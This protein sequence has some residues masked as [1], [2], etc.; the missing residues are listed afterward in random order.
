MAAYVPWKN[1][2]LL[3]SASSA[4]TA[5]LSE[6][7]ESTTDSEKIIGLSSI[8]ER[9]QV[10]RVDLAQILSCS[11]YMYTSASLQSLHWLRVK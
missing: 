10:H 9:V 6:H 7:V 4:G 11:S 1:N 5:W 8:Y 3:R 2:G